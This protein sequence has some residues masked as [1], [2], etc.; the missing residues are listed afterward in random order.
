MS[1]IF[2]LNSLEMKKKLYQDSNFVVW[3]VSACGDEFL[4]QKVSPCRGHT[5][6]NSWIIENVKLQIWEIR[7]MNGG[8]FF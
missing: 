3:V 8:P 5:R 7:N 6:H 4:K 1:Q 2:F